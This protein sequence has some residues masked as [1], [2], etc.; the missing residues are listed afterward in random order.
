MSKCQIARIFAQNNSKAADA[1]GFESV[2]G[3]V[4]Q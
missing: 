2:F 3:F 4:G 1:M